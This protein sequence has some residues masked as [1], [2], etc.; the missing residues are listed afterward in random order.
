MTT[1]ARPSP[2][3]PGKRGSARSPTPRR[4]ATVDPM[5]PVMTAL[6]A[7]LVLA[8][9]ALPADP[10]GFY[11]WKAADLKK[12]PATLAPKVDPATGL[13]A[14]KVADLGNYS[15]LT[16]L[17]KSSGAVEVHETQN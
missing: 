3:P 10:A 1:P 4:C 8:G 15:F 2:S 14:V 13:V 6:L 16:I 11:F 7:A 5:K 9:L 12:L 17:R